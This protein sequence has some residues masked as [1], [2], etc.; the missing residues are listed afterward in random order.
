[1]INVFRGVNKLNWSCTR[2]SIQIRFVQTWTSPISPLQI[3]KN[4]TN[5]VNSLIKY[6][7]TPKK[8]KTHP[9]NSIKNKFVLTHT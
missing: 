3:L 9:C 6:N 4:K 7:K 2:V 5:I 1:M 8:K